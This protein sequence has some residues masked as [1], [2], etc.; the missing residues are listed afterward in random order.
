MG[1]RR[2]ELQDDHEG[3][4]PYLE[5]FKDLNKGSRVEYE[6]NPDDTIK[7]LFVCPRIMKKALMYKVVRK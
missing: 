7:H 4:I 3:M 2:Q 5:K 1:Q 6:V